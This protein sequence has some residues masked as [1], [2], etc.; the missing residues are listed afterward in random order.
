MAEYDQ[1]RDQAYRA[2]MIVRDAGLAIL[3]W[4]NASQVDR[5][6]GVMAIKPSGVSYDELGPAHMVIVSLEDGAVVDGDLRPSSDTPT[7]LA[8]YRAF[9]DIG[10][11]VHTHSH[12][13][14]SW[15]QAMQPIPCL[16]TTHADTFHGSIPV[17][18]LMHDDEIATDY[19]ANTGEVVAEHFSRY[20][21]NAAHTPGVLVAHHGPFAWGKDALAAAENAMI[22]EEVARMAFHTRQIAPSAS[23]APENLVEKHFQRKHGKNAYYGQ[24]R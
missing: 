19:E 2:N 4:G 9:A 16:G 22:L 24:K 20:K 3:T 12:F 21:I 8:L 18:R 10:G 14:T 23:P 11:I 17:T 13:A 5:K 1:I 7:H 15:A 6:N